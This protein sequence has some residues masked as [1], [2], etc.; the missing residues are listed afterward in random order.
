MALQ[1][2]SEALKYFE[3][4][5]GVARANVDP[6]LISRAESMISMVRANMGEA[7]HVK[8]AFINRK[9]MYETEA[10]SC[11][12]SVDAIQ[13]G[14]EYAESL[15]KLH[16]RG[17]ES[18]RL[19]MKLH[20]ICQR[21]HGPDHKLTK[22]VC[23]K[24]SDRSSVWMRSEVTVDSYMLMDYDGSFD[25][26]V[27]MN[28]SP[29]ALLAML[30]DGGGLRLPIE[31]LSIDE[32]VF[33]KGTIVYSS[34]QPVGCNGDLDQ[35]VLG[36]MRRSQLVDEVMLEEYDQD[37]ADGR[38]KPTELNF[39]DLVLGDV[40]AW[41]KDTKC[42]TIHWE[43]ESIPPCAVPRDRVFVPNCIC[44][45]CIESKQQFMFAPNEHFPKNCEWDRQ[46]K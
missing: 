11:E 20:E 30:S 1:L 15:K 25:K 10:Q 19:L 3:K 38:A 33:D 21:V 27:V 12:S 7:E 24:K 23:S 29:N 5:L 9:K 13:L 31:S 2:F 41:D 42:Y 44:N 8:P 46:D 43:D 39:K 16:H 35:F 18:A 14:V 4:S 45:K 28:K 32:V 36:D 40:R 17:V 6:E 34:P 26:C 22:L 37:V